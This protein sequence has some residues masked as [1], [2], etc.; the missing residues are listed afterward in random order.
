MEVY[1]FVIFFLLSIIKLSNIR[2][3]CNSAALCFRDT[4]NVIVC[5]CVSVSVELAE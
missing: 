3:F 5:F 4:G 1:R 2:P